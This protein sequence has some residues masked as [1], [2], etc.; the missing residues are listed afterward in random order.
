MFPWTLDQKSFH[1]ASTIF[2]VTSDCSC[3]VVNI[4]SKHLGLHPLV[5]SNFLIL[6]EI[7]DT[8]IVK[9]CYIG[10]TWPNTI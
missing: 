6:T 2:T 5:L 7:K 3:K 9:A 4:V 1:N 10:D 8:D